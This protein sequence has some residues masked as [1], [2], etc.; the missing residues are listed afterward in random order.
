M[1]KVNASFPHDAYK[2][3]VKSL[4]DQDTAGV[5][6]RIML[7]PQGVWED[8]Q[9]KIAELDTLHDVDAIDDDYLTYLKHHVGWTR[10]L[11][12][13]TESLSAAELRKLITLSVA[14]WKSRGTELGIKNAIRLLVGR[15][16]VIWNWFHMRWTV[17]E[18]G[19]WVLGAET[20]SWMLGGYDEGQRGEY[21]STIWVMREQGAEI[22]RQLLRDLVDLHR[23]LQEVYL[24][25]YAGLVDD[26][27]L[28]IRKWK[29]IPPTATDSRWDD[30]NFRL[31]LE[32]G[33][34]RRANVNGIT[35]WLDVQWRTQIR[36]KGAGDAFRII[37][38]RQSDDTRYEATFW[39]DGS[40]QVERF[41]GGAGV[42]LGTA[43]LPHAFPVDE[44]QVIGLNVFRPSAGQLRIA[45]MVYEQERLVGEIT[46]PDHLLPGGAWVLENAS[47]SIENVEVDNV[48]AYELPLFVDVVEGPGTTGEPAAAPA[49][50]PSVVE[51]EN[52]DGLGSWTL[53]GLW[54][55]TGFRYWSPFAS[56]YFGTGETGYHTWGVAGSMGGGIVTGT[57]TSPVFDLSSWTADRFR[58]FLDFR[59]RLDVR[60][61]ADDIAAV[62]VRV[63]GVTVQTIT[64]A[65]LL[66]AGEVVRVNITAAAAGQAAVT[67]RFSMD[68]VTIPSPADEGWFVDDLRILAEEA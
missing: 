24:V 26:F 3:L 61:G 35:D 37:F 30:E 45:V 64:K 66:A 40:L 27:S 41:N 13:I 28:G 39:Q 1:S 36:F 49:I 5:L 2:F 17:G 68:T 43:A 58:L 22:D 31:I 54:H 18:S 51:V 34:R 55:S 38:R 52:M 42:V 63:S 23:P 11:D 33:A 65:Q 60:A 44:P 46:D 29:P 53:T 20:D 21:T 7:G 32:P 59:Q 67:I 4:R 6:E 16:V 47:T 14:F 25:A 57:A 48:I 9:A 15:D 62:E 12:H 10:E 50:S 8:F 56:L 19:F